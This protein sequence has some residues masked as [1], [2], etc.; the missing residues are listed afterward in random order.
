MT[1]DQFWAIIEEVHRN[2]AGN[3]DAKCELL[4]TTL[5]KLP[6]DEVRSFDEHFREQYYRAYDWGLWAAAYIIGHGCS[7]DSFM[8]FRSTLISMGRETFER[9]LADPES[10]AELD[11]DAEASALR[12]FPVCER[13]GL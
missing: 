3:M 12:G 11:Y 7:D 13:S 9:A 1:L 8:D 4:G 6:L 5:R 10:L 2:S